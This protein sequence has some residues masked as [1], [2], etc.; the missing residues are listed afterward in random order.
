MFHCCCDGSR[1]HAVTFFTSRSNLYAGWKSDSNLPPGGL[2]KCL[3]DHGPG[4]HLRP[5]ASGFCGVVPYRKIAP[6]FPHTCHTAV[7]TAGEKAFFSPSRSPLLHS[8]NN[9][10]YLHIIRRK[11]D[12]KRRTWLTVFSVATMAS[13]LCTAFSVVNFQLFGSQLLTSYECHLL[14]PPVELIT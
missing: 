8:L 6:S 1:S 4:P 10:S 14:L 13:F 9:L 11:D 5:P 12:P 2:F 7:F 3:P